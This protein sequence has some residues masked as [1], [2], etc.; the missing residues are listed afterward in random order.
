MALALFPGFPTLFVLQVGASL[1]PRLFSPVKEPGNKAWSGLLL[2]LA[3]VHRSI[4]QK[5][6]KPWNEARTAPSVI[7]CE[8][9]HHF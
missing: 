7:P 1:V 5:W 6:G 8:L 2:V 3:H 4:I 9:W